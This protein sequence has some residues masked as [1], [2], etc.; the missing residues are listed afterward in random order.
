VWLK[1]KVKVKVMMKV[2]AKVKVSTKIEGRFDILKFSINDVPNPSNGI[3]S[4]KKLELESAFSK[5]FTHLL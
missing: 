5:H 4:I 1:V 2:K 3:N